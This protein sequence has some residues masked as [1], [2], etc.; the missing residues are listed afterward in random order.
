MSDVAKLWTDIAAAWDDQDDK[1]ALAELDEFFETLEMKG[2]PSTP[3]EAKRD[4]ALFVELLK[5]CR[6]HVTAAGR[7][8]DIKN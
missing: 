5:R 8:I 3:E 7:E 4:D 1:T 6:D 2:R